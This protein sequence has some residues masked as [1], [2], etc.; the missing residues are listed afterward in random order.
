MGSIHN[1]LD[2]ADEYDYS[3]PASA[4]EVYERGIL[5]NPL[6]AKDLP[7]EIRSRPTSITFIGSNS[8]SIPVNWRFA[9]AVSSLKALEAALTDVVLQRLYGLGP[10][11]V[12]I[13]TDHATLFLFSTLLWTIDPG[14]GGENITASNLRQADERLFK[15]FPN[16]DKHRMNAS[17]HRNL[18]TNIYKCSDGR[19]FQSHGSLNPTPTLS[20]VGLP[21]ELEAESYEQGVANVQGAFHKIDSTALQNLT[22]QSRQ[23]GTICYTTKE[24]LQSEHGRAN[25]HVGLWEIHNRPN[26][27]QSPCWWTPPTSGRQQSRPLSGLKVVDLTRIIAGPSITRS[28]AELGASVMRCTAPHLPDVVSLQADLN[29]GKWNCSLDLRT[30][31]GREKLKAL[32]YEADVVVQGY[33]PG[34]LDKFG[35]GQEDI[36][37]IFDSRERGGVY[38]RENCYGWHGPWKDRSGWQQIAD[39]VS[40]TLC[41]V[42]LASC[43]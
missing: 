17:I 8:P 5:A 1:K 9:E 36:V 23:A 41:R 15:Y 18:A 40:E 20:N 38:V 32:I 10:H 34:A 42:H 30:E 35:F 11:H 14:K 27:A 29:W 24:Y 21:A 39:A 13:N 4:A 19:F 6:I 25:Q 3:V 28:L 12:K 7:D 22:D 26:A 31:S 43:S 33:R 37:R 16:C 2:I